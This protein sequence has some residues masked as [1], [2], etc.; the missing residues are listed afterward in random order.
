MHAT[1]EQ[2]LSLRDGQPVAAEAAAHVLACPEC[3]G[4]VARLE[5]TR[6]RLRS[7]PPVRPPQG[8]WRAAATVTSTGARPRRIHWATVAGF[9]A[10]FVLGLAL[11]FRMEPDERPPAETRVELAAT[12]PVP[13]VERSRQLEAT[14]RAMPA[15][16]HVTRVGTALTVSNLEDQIHRIDLRLSSGEMPP[17]YEEALWRQ[18]VRLMDSLVRVR[19][20]QISDSR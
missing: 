4:E 5:E 12:S 8:P 15:A 1:T 13:L 17:D 20:A 14:L 3:R 6:R 16:P 11:I 9:A 18:R 10:S 19:Y 2:L 7:L